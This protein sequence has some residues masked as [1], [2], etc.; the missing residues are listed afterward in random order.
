MLSS[1]SALLAIAI[2]SLLLVAGCSFGSPKPHTFAMGERADLGGLIYTVLD[3]QWITQIGSG[4]DAKVPR[5]RYL[6]VRLS[7][8][9]SGVADALVPS[10]TL[11]D[12][13][14]E[15]YAELPDA[16]G[17]PHWLG[18][19]RQAKPAEVA[20]GNVV[21][22]APPRHYKLRLT[23]ENDQKT[24]F[25]DLPLNFNPDTLELS[26]PDSAKEPTPGVK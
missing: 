12:D 25:V 4:L 23:D 6:L 17:V 8:A 26:I 19:L 2:L 15:T 18:V 5:N 24:A 1:R 16:G 11:V 10:L 3:T 20:Q 14:G 22:D 9:N 7:V 21:F 13:N